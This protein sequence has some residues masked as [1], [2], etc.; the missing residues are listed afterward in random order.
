MIF[1]PVWIFILCFVG[2]VG[3]AIISLVGW[4]HS[5]IVLAE[6]RFENQT[7]QKKI[8][9][10]ENEVFDYRGDE[11]IRIANEFNE[12]C[13]QEGERNKEGGADVQV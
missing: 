9:R 6:E 2:L 4:I 10:L 7:A 1:M 13:L 8:A 3:I 11:I 12:Q 5:D